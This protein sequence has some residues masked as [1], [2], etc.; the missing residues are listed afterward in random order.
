MR[1]KRREREK[2]DRKICKREDQTKKIVKRKQKI[3][4]KKQNLRI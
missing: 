1:K 4:R 3:H 2:S